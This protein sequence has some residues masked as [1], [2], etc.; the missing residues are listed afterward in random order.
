MHVATN[1]DSFYLKNTTGTPPGYQMFQ[2][3]ELGGARLH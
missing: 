2:T 1:G 3:T